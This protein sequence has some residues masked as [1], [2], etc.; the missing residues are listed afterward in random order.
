[1]A[2]RTMYAGANNSVPTK[3]TEMLMATD[4]TVAVEDASVLPPG[5]NIATLGAEDNAEVVSYASISGNTLT[6]CL[7]G[8]GGTLA[9]IWPE[10]TIV[11]RAYTNYDHETF[12]RNIK[13]L[14]ANK[15]G[16]SGDASEAT[17]GFTQA[18]A[19]EGIESGWSL[20]KLFG[21]IAKWLA[22][23]KPG[24]FADFG[25][26]NAQIARG[27]HAHAQYLTAETDPTVPAWAKTE[28]KPT[29]TAAETG[30]VPV[31]RKVAGKALDA[32]VT[33]APGD[34]GAAAAVHEHAEYLTAETDPT[35]S[36][37]AKASEKPAYTADEVG[38]VTLADG[39]AAAEQTSAAV[40]AVTGSYTLALSDAGRL[41][42]VSSAGAAT[43]TVPADATVNFPVGTEIEIM[44]E[45]AG[46]VT[47][48]AAGGVTLRSPGDKFV[49]SEQYAAAVLK[50]RGPN[51]W[52]TWGAL[53]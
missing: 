11:Y 48:A 2:Q 40:V 38:A 47:I 22:D 49:I 51:D 25:T 5:P 7:R 17:A 26:G 18:G 33:L 6:G 28:T 9:Q 37:W 15:L 4:T 52:R 45:G 30:S 35:V 14:D 43:V 39:K 46:E 19:R 1:M 32:D 50:K 13:D 21:R 8:F 44:Q 23:L 53:K 20:G 12:I 31:T 42:E 24:A 29:Y 27:D 36:A 3:I 10:N 16:V 34:V 41:V